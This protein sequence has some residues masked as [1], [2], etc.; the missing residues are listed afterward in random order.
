[1]RKLTVAAALVGLVAG[2]LFMPAIATAA[3][4]TSQVSAQ[5]QRSGTLT[6]SIDSGICWGIDATDHREQAIGGGELTLRDDGGHYTVQSGTLT[7]DGHEYSV[8]SGTL[9][10]VTT[11]SFNYRITS[12]TLTLGGIEFGIRAT[13]VAS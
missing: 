3:P 5:A 2:G 8:N 10:L 1:M 9:T 12:G 7:V 13:A 11:D 4:T 6:L